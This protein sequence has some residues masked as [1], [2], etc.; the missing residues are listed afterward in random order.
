MILSNLLKENDALLKSH[1]KIVGVVGDLQIGR[2]YILFH[3]LPQSFDWHRDGEYESNHP[4]YKKTKFEAAKSYEVVKILSVTPVVDK[5]EIPSDITFDKFITWNNGFV[6]I[7]DEDVAKYSFKKY[8]RNDVRSYD[9]CEFMH[10]E[11]KYVNV[12]TQVEGA[13][14]VKSYQCTMEIL[15]TAYEVETACQCENRTV[16]YSDKFYCSDCFE[17]DC[18]QY[19]GANGKHYMKLKA[20]KKTAALIKNVLS[21]TVHDEIIRNFK[22]MLAKRMLNNVDDIKEE[23]TIEIDGLTWYNGFRNDIGGSFGRTHLF[24]DYIPHG[25]R[26]PTNEEIMSMLKKHPLLRKELYKED[27]KGKDNY[28]RALRNNVGMQVYYS[29]YYYNIH[30]RG[31]HL[32]AVTQDTNVYD[33]E[34]NYFPAR[35]SCCDVSIGRIV[36]RPTSVD[37][38]NND[39]KPY[40]VMIVKMTD[41]EL[42]KQDEWCYKVLEDNIAFSTLDDIYKAYGVDS[43]DDIESFEFDM[44]IGDKKKTFKKSKKND[45][46]RNLMHAIAKYIG[47]DDVFK[48]D[49]LD[50]K[51]RGKGVDG[52]LSFDAAKECDVRSYLTKIS[53]LL[54]EQ[55]CLYN[56]NT[57]KMLSKRENDYINDKFTFT[58]I[59]R[60]YYRDNGN[61]PIKMYFYIKDALNMIGIE[62]DRLGYEAPSS[63]YY[64]GHEFAMTAYITK[65]TLNMKDGRKVVIEKLPLKCFNMSWFYIDELKKDLSESTAKF[66]EDLDKAL[67][68]EEMMLKFVK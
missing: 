14:N 56:I 4:F 33:D 24:Y 67:K 46:L 53:P 25:W 68:K 50:I 60:R 49:K 51:F 42:K 10:F 11:V 18:E 8:M 13:V 1:I 19:E 48:S 26:L 44:N 61:I 55:L 57:I 30:Q 38:L 21:T 65:L 16:K 64:Y 41:E 45:N 36:E 35:I 43:I 9:C 2:K 6:T 7:Y 3:A 62:H 58:H 54:C 29:G 12:D 27:D 28:L 37:T 32:Y 22:V 5:N 20:E 63:G 66:V 23:D 34:E 15:G 52:A 40:F 47:N 17:Y 59:R 31:R 39:L